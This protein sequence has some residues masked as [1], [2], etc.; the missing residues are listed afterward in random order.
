MGAISP[1]PAPPAQRP[2]GADAAPERPGAASG[3][4]ALWV[5]TGL[6]G[7]LSFL[8]M[9][10]IGI[11]V[12]PFALALFV[13]ATILTARRADRWP[14]LAGLGIAAA[15]ALAWLGNVLGH[16]LPSSGS[17]T[18][19]AVPGGAPPGTPSTCVSFD[20]NSRP[21][22]PQAFQWGAAWPWFLAAAVLAVLTVAG[23]LLARRRVGA[24]AMTGSPD[25][26]AP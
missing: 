3:L 8:G 15:I 1:T 11:F 17:G 7:A 10:T 19:T 4:F 2:G 23:C 5:L 16:S 14:A 9:L 21:F 12:A 22:G 24:G 18:C 26:G 25:A 13:T 6:T 20:E